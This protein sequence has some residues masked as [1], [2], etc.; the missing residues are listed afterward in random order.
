MNEY[1]SYM[2]NSVELGIID[3]SK[4]EN[5]ESSENKTQPLLNNNI[6]KKEEEKKEKNI[7]NE[8]INIHTS[9]PRKIGKTWGFLY[10]KDYPLIII[11]PD[12]K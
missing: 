12:C 11:G 8:N 5:E 4:N 3:S 1:E 10:Y 7:L 9:N 6:N 2:K